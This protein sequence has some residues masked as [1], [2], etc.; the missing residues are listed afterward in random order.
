MK[1]VFADTFFF[2]AILNPRDRACRR[3]V[4]LSRSLI[5]RRVTTAWVLTEVADAMA[6]PTN[7]AVFLGFITALEHNPAVDIIPAS[8]G[9]YRRGLEF[10]RSRPDKAWSL[11]DCVS[12]AVMQEQGLREALTGDHHFTQAGFVALL[13]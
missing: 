5:A 13:G 4:E 10:Y 7:R 6:Q 2:L 9:L 12:F 1:T 11:T 8:D 3:S